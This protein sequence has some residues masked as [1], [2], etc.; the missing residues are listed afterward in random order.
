MTYEPVLGVGER[1]QLLPT[2]K[3]MSMIPRTSTNSKPRWVALASGVL[4]LAV[5]AT[6]ALSSS[7]TRRAAS[8]ME[9][10][11]PP[12]PASSTEDYGPPVPILGKSKKPKDVDPMEVCN[13]GMYSKRT[14]KLAYEQSMTAL[15]NSYESKYE[16]S[17]VIVVDGQAHVVCDSSWSIYK[18]GLDLQPR[19]ASNVR[20]GDPERVSGE[21]SSYEAIA[22]FEDVFYVM[23]ESIQH[24]DEAYH[25]IVEE[26][27]VDGEQYNVQ[28]T[29]STE[30]EFEGDSKGFEG[31]W[32]VR[33]LQGELILIGLCEGNRCSEKYKKDRGNGRIV[34]MKQ[35]LNENVDDPCVWETIKTVNIPASAF[36]MDY[37]AMAVHE[38]G[39]VAITSQ[40]ESQVWIGR[41]LGRQSG[42]LWDI[43]EI[44]FDEGVGKVFD[45]PKNDQ[46]FGVY[47][48]VEG[49]AWLDDGT[50]LAVSDKMKSKGK[51]DFRCQAK[52]QSVHVFALP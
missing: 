24:E 42:E 27:V 28:R 15:F 25:A 20:L 7:S 22:F 29:C 52:D 36:F 11:G 51:Q 46:G 1:H 41:L 39:N 18:F 2:N 48:N 50:L 43:D 14:L 31:M 49:I 5:G 32:P 45:F 19:A 3:G 26:I 40:E 44:Q 13:D 16:A 23:R 9:D 6:V 47:C 33:D 12:V 21:D 10:Y 30:F 35:A 4:L 34:I 8:S 37:S 38:N 17:A